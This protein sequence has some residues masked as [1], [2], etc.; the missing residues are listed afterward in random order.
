[1]TRW[2]RM[3]RDGRGSLRIFQANVGKSPPAHDCALALAD[4][5]Q[6]CKSRYLLGCRTEPEVDITDE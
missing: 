2:P 4:T 6:F 3:N 5:E 1:M